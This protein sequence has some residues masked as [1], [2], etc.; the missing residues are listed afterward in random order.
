[1]LDFILNIEAAKLKF[2][3]L[4][5][6]NIQKKIKLGVVKTESIEKIFSIVC[7]STIIKLY[8]IC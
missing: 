1:M 7:L 6:L 8:K 5:E 4:F 2:S 3:S